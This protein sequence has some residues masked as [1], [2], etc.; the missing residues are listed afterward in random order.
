MNKII[1][2]LFGFCISLVANTYVTSSATIL[3]NDY[4]NY[5][6]TKMKQ[7]VLKQAKLK[8]SKEIYGEFLA[9]DIK[10]ED[11][12]IIDD[13]I[14]LKSGGIVHLK[15]KPTYQEN[16]KSIKVTIK[17]YATDM[18][19]GKNYKDI[20][21]KIKS[22]KNKKVDYHK[23]YVGLWSGFLMGDD[24]SSADVDV[25]ITNYANITIY[26]NSMQCG[27]DLV[28]V[29]KNNNQVKLKEFL[30]F[31]KDRCVNNSIITLRKATPTSLEF[32]Q[33][34]DDKKIFSGRV[35]LVK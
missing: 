30:T 18:D 9:S 1:F 11:G 15:G 35:Y 29:E 20:S 14:R 33:T 24:G 25:S 23:N 26:Y 27:G 31:G 7:E 28:T 5:T 22:Y 34:H 16:D 2:I 3:K 10:M 17:A 13:V 4:T 12:H 19:L 8:A 32:I 21:N 6:I